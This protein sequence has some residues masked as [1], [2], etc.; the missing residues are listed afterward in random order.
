M[1]E[2]FDCLQGSPEWHQLRA[3]IPTASEF[4]T[5]RA[6][7]RGGEESKTRR[8]LLLEKAGEILTGTPSISYSNWYMENGK[9][10][11]AEARDLYAEYHV[12]TADQIGF[13]KNGRAGC[14]PDALIGENGLLEIKTALPHL[15]LDILLRQEFPPQYKAQCQGALWIAER[16]W[17]DLAIY[18]P[19]LPLFVKR[20]YRDQG[21]IA[22][23]VGAV[24][25]FNAELDEIVEKVKRIGEPVPSLKEQLQQ[26]LAALEIEA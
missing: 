2:F 11:E 16:E 4:A 21:Y 1:P 13:I 9:A 7:G 10:K 3:G 17:I 20:A 23:L 25:V 5:V 18:W 19:G 24:A 22:N 15:L 8:K 6:N 26:S 12:L 14:S